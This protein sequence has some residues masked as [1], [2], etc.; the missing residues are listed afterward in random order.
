MTTA[1]ADTERTQ[2]A[3]ETDRWAKHTLA[4]VFHDAA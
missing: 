4:L 2:A 1:N 3:P